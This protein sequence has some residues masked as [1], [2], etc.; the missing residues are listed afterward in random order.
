MTVAPE[1]AGE[2]TD[3][4]GKGDVIEFES[5]MA[6]SVMERGA[7]GEIEPVDCERAEIELA[8]CPRPVDPPVRV[9]PEIERHS[10]DREFDGPPFAPHERA[11]AE[12]DVELVG[13]HLAEIVGPADND[14][15]QQIG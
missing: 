11:E 7:A 13:A 14:R 9:E 8:T 3:I 1:R 2:R 12:L 6:R 5:T 4:A 15:A 10:A